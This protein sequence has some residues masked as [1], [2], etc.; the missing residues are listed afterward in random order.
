M[1]EQ[2][3]NGTPVIL[4]SYLFIEN[5]KKEVVREEKDKKR[6]EARS[7]LW[8]TKL[9]DEAMEEKKKQKEIK[10]SYISSI[11]A[12]FNPDILGGSF[13]K[14]PNKGGSDKK[15]FIRGNEYFTKKVSAQKDDN[16]KDNKRD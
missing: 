8:E 3:K 4:N 10:A 11:S 5:T 7:K 12:K 2:I 6:K 14:G 16:L 9:E 1:P 13:L 15:E